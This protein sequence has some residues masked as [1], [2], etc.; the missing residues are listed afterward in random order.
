MQIPFIEWAISLH[1][2]CIV[3]TNSFKSMS[4]IAHLGGGEHGMLAQ[5]LIQV[6]GDVVAAGAWLRLDQHR[7][8]GRGGRGGQ[9]WILRQGRLLLLLLSVVD[10]LGMDR[11]LQRLLLLLLFVVDLLGM[12]RSV[13]R[14]VLLL[15][16]VQDLRLLL[17]LSSGHEHLL[18][19]CLLLLLLRNGDETSLLLRNR[20]SASLWRD[21]RQRASLDALLSCD[22]RPPQLLRLLLLLGEDDLGFLLLLLLREDDPG[23]LQV[24]LLLRLQQL[25]QVLGGGRGP[26]HPLLEHTF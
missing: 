1:F 21:L 20:D 7:R 2:Y 10:L 14:L 5:Q 11:S 26:S 6:E 23:P 8:R 4:T 19:R 18:Q 15:L 3:I 25:A 13:Q 12:D 16:D 17:V 22:L 9:G 24:L